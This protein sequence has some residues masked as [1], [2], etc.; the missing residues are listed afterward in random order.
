MAVASSVTSVGT[1][2]VALTVP[3]NGWVKNNGGVPVFLGGST[4]TADSSA[5]GG[6]L[7]NVGERIGPFVTGGTLNA[8]AASLVDVNPTAQIAILSGLA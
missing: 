5:T 2:R 7:L 1:T 3:A 8:V 4:V 6:L